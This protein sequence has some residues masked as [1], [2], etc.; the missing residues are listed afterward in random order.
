MHPLFR[1]S[2]T[3]TINHMCYR[4]RLSSLGDDYACN[5]EAFDHPIIYHNIFS[6]GGADGGRGWHVSWK[7]FFG[8]F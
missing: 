5:F 6:D 1:G 2:T 7:K 4:I 8:K 3:E